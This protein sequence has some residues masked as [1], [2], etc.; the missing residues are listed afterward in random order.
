MD[1]KNIYKDISTKFQKYKYVGIVVV[2]GIV[3]MLLPNLSFEEKKSDVLP[4][5]IEQT[6]SLQQELEQILSQ[7]S[8]AGRVRIMLNEQVGE[9]R[10][11]QYNE[12]ITV[13]DSVTSTKNSI[14]TVADADRNENGLIKKIN[15]PI[16]RGAIVLCQGAD[17]P[18]VK[19]AVSEAVSKITGLG[20]DKII[21]LKMK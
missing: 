16:Y 4:D 10:I 5:T 1:I 20:L 12:D 13:S 19:L 11:Y 21:V 14:V 9:E 17:N 18:V 8:G 3:L 6:I 7:I 2:V 15:S